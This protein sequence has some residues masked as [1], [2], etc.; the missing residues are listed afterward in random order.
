[1]SPTWLGVR[2]P[3]ICTSYLAAESSCMNL[4]ILDL[5]FPLDIPCSINGLTVASSILSF[6]HYLKPTPVMSPS[7]STVLIPFIEKEWS[8]WRTPKLCFKNICFFFK[9]LS[10]CIL[11]GNCM[12]QLFPHLPLFLLW[13][14]NHCVNFNLRN[15][16]DTQYT[17]QFLSFSI[18]KD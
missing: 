2:C 13:P 4:S 11:T 17:F 10:F 3:C 14:H 7:I 18:F 16:I 8:F 6:P 1:M 5:L 12:N 9:F 15:L